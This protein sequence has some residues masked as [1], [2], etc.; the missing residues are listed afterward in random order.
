MGRGSYPATSRSVHVVLRGSQRYAKI[1]APRRNPMPRAALTIVLVS[2]A[3]LALAGDKPS[4]KKEKEIT[5]AGTTAYF[6]YL[7]VADGRLY[8]AHGNSIDVVDLEKGEKVG[9]V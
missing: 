9:E 1:R 6:D 4:F 8:V 7:T 2:F 3:S 5:R